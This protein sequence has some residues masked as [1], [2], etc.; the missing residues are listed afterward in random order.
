MVP[1]PALASAI[2]ASF[3]DNHSFIRS[4]SETFTVYA[5]SQLSY[6]FSLL[7]KIT[8]G[9]RQFCLKSKLLKNQTPYKVTSS[10]IRK[11]LYRSFLKCSHDASFKIIVNEEGEVIFRLHSFISSKVK[12]QHSK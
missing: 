10:E 9:K 8:I 1:Y 11:N 12:L 6:S 4:T 2:K 5:S 7:T 3:F